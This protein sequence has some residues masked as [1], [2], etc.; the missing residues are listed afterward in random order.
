M[1]RF[2]TVIWGAL[3]GTADGPDERPELRNAWCCVESQDR[4]C[5]P[6]ASWPAAV[7]LF[8][9]NQRLVGRFQ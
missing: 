6:S 2:V 1:H 9:D 8:F 7:V 4:C 3:L 5:W